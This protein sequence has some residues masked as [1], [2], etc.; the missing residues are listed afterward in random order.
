[1]RRKA[2]GQLVGPQPE[3]SDELPEILDM[4]GLEKV[5]DNAKV[6][7]EQLSQL[8]KWLDKLGEI[9]EKMSSE[10]TGPSYKDKLEDRIKSLGYARY[11]SNPSDRRGADFPG[12]GIGGCQIENPTVPG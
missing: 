3:P 12:K 5:L 6:W 11:S 10:P 2:P 8:K 1:V 4:E 7:K 9:R